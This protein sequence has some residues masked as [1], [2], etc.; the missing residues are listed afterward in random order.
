MKILK[1]NS[2]EIVTDCQLYFG[3]PLVA[4]T[5]LRNAKLTSFQKS[6]PPAKY[7]LNCLCQLPRPR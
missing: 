5:L 2:N 1:T 7:R 6:P 3:F 4:D